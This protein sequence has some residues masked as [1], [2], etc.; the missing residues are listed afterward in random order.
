MGFYPSS[1]ALKSNNPVSSLTLLICGFLLLI[2]IPSMEFRV[3]ILATN[4]VFTVVFYVM[5]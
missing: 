2:L 4:S 1:D 3:L 5:R